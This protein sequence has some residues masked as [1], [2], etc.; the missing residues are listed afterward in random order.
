MFNP[1]HNHSWFFCLIKCKFLCYCCY[2]VSSVI[3]QQAKNLQGYKH[4]FFPTLHLDFLIP[5]T[6]RL[7]VKEWYYLGVVTC[8]SQLFFCTKNPWYPETK[9]MATSRAINPFPTECLGWHTPNLSAFEIRAL[10]K[11]FSF[12]ARAVRCRYRERIRNARLPKFLTK[13]WPVKNRFSVKSAPS[14]PHHFHLIQQFGNGF[15]VLKHLAS[16]KRN[17]KQKNVQKRFKV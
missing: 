2:I 16:R 11:S 17:F 4:Y 7:K 10:R 15:D 13:K 8:F 12:D 5:L 1:F 9:I 14:L 6:I 3:R